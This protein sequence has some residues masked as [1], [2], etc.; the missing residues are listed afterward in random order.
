MILEGLV[1][2]VVLVILEVLAFL[3]VLV[4]LDLLGILFF[5]LALLDFLE[6]QS[7]DFCRSRPRI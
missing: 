3:V 2:L 1:F 7:Y 6:V 4:F 5:F